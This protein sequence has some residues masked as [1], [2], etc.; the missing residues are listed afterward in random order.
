MV[1]GSFLSAIAVFGSTFGNLHLV[2]RQEMCMSREDVE[3][4][5]VSFAFFQLSSAKA[6]G[7][8]M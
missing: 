8:V 7:P 4:D 2:V 6:G 1:N 5:E 3:S